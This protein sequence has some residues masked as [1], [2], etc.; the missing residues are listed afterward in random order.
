[1]VPERGSDSAHTDST[2]LGRQ[3]TREACTATLRAA[4]T[5]TEQPVS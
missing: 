3:T 4:S 5:E 1:M 2:G